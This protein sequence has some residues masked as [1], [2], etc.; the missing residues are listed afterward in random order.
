M[1]R[2]VSCGFCFLRENDDG[3]IIME[4]RFTGLLIEV[5]LARKVYK[6]ISEVC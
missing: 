2:L 4:N 5:D 3:K 6:V 1:K